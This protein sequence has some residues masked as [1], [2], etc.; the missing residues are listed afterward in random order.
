MRSITLDAAAPPPGSRHGLSLAAVATASS[1]AAPAAAAAGA[2][3]RAGPG[4]R[5]AAADRRMMELW[6]VQ[7]EELRLER[8]IGRGSFG[9]VYLAY[10]HETAV[11]AKVLIMSG[12]RGCLRL[13]SPARLACGLR[14]AAPAS[15]SLRYKGPL[16]VWAAQACPH[17]AGYPAAAAE[18]CMPLAVPACLP[19]CRRPGRGRVGAA[20]GHPAQPARGGRRL[21]PARQ[22]RERLPWHATCRAPILAAIPPPLRAA[23][24]RSARAR[25]EALARP[26]THACL[27]CPGLPALPG[28][29]LPLPPAG[30]RR[31]P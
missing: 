17:P 1:A 20:A 13:R 24:T 4:S 3:G 15:P 27:R 19:A 30:R 23:E 22:P 6:Q 7:W 26:H 25:Q 10:W 21:Q 14:Q 8:M 31:R 11:A 9:F 5:E 29:S 16:R 12:A 2:S 28:P 18:Q